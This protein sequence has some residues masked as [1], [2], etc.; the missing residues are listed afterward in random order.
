MPTLSWVAASTTSLLESGRGW[1]E[2]GRP[3]PGA[4][5]PARERGRRVCPSGGRVVQFGC[6]HAHGH[7][8]LLRTTD[9]SCAKDPG[10][11][12]CMRRDP[13]A[14]GTTGIEIDLFRAC[15]AA[16]TEA[17]F[18][19][20]ALVP[21]LPRGTRTPEAPMLRKLFVV[22]VALSSTA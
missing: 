12:R 2:E 6:G 4:C 3:D 20:C 15:I 16:D 19:M 10:S 14:A 7:A 8:R 5:L 1:R 21:S 13:G 22:L 17:Q 9:G 11:G 18:P